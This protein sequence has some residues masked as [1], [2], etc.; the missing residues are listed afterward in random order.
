ME[1]KST[2]SLGRSY[3]AQS[4]IEWETAEKEDNGKA[5][6]RLTSTV[7]QESKMCFTINLTK[8]TPSSLPAHNLL[9][10]VDKTCCFHTDKGLR[11]PLG[12][13]NTSVARVCEK[14]ITFCSKFE[15][16]IR[17]SSIHGEY[18]E[19]IGLQRELIDYMELAIYAAAEHVDDLVAIAE[20][21]FKD[22]I[23]F[24]KDA[25]V[26]RLKDD[27]QDVKAFISA[28]ANAI[29]HQQ[30]R[31]RLY[32]LEFSHARIDSVLYGFFVEEVKDGVIG[33][34]SMLDKP[35]SV[36]SISTLAW[37]IILF[38]LLCSDLLKRFLLSCA[39]FCNEAVGQTSDLLAQA[40]ILAARLPLFTFEEEH[41]F[42]R[43][44]FVLTSSGGSVKQELDSGLYGSFVSRWSLSGDVRF[45]KSSA[46]FMG[47]GST[48]VFKLP[49]PS[50]VSLQHWY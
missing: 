44:T 21:F 9:A 38:L 49:L 7:N 2:N 6:T 42:S 39:S 47:E 10:A 30:A 14:L 27:I 36:F 20:G 25:N 29:K 12:I 17:I 32:S 18:E 41:P 50:K 22:N 24:K 33:P 46:S 1:G 34:K 16:F 15:K 48:I 11:L 45:G 40:V 4:V 5:I 13:Y 26:K 8:G 31:M 43:A 28:T 37:E 3:V 19:R 35:P 23:T